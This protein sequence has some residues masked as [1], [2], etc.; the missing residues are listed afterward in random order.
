MKTIQTHVLG[1]PRIGAR[2]E[3]KHALEAYWRGASSCATLENVGA[4]LRARHWGVQKEA[5][6]DLVTVG[7]LPSMT[8]SPTTSSCSAAN[9]PASALPISPRWRAI[10]R[11]RAA[12]AATCRDTAAVTLTPGTHST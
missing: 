4:S 1:F 8:R 2:R 6:L 5:G 3:L 9:R 10:L 11:W 12:A 7:D